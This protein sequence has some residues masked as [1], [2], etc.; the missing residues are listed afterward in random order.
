MK[1]KNILGIL[2]ILPGSLK[3]S[4]PKINKGRAQKDHRILKL[5]FT[6]KDFSEPR[7]LKL[8]FYSFKRCEAKKK[9]S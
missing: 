8:W 5:A 1:Y 3:Y 2:M 4:G 6:L 9:V 7:E